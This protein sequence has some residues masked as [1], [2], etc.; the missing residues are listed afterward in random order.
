MSIASKRAKERKNRTPN[1]EDMAKIVE[2]MLL[3]LGGAV[4]PLGRA[5]VPLCSGKS[6]DLIMGWTWG[7]PNSNF[8]GQ[9]E[10]EKK[11]CDGFRGGEVGK[12]KIHLPN[13]KIMNQTQQNLTRTNKMQKIWEAIFGGDF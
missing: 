4:V 3:K 6:S 2:L 13:N 10:G 9:I 11:I 5:V 7:G 12:A 8:W 1:V